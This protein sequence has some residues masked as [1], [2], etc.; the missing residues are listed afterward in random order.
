MKKHTIIGMAVAAAA[1][2][3]GWCIT[4]R[5]RKSQVDE[6]RYQVR[7]LLAAKRNELDAL[8]KAAEAGELKP[9]LLGPVPMEGMDVEAVR[10]EDGLLTL[11]LGNKG[12]RAWLSDRPLDE[13]PVHTQPWQGSARPGVLYTESLGDGWYAGYACLRWK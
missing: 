3:V 2:T 12:A 7:R 5:R 10:L 1:G 11:S 6:I 8:R 9:E 4:A 13:L